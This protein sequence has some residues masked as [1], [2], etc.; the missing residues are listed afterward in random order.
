MRDLE[1]LTD[2]VRRQVERAIGGLPKGETGPLK[3][4]WVGYRKLKVVDR[5]WRVIYRE[6]RRRRQ[7]TVVRVVE[8]SEGYD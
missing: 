5:E 1:R 6:D 3:G 8:R 7:V 4:K 2:D